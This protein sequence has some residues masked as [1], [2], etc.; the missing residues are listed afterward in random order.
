MGAPQIIHTAAGEELVV[1]PRAD[2]E[3]LLAR[4]GDS[5]AED[6]VTAR[7]LAETDRAVAEGQ[8]AAL[9]EAVWEAIEA[10]AHP[11]AALRKWRGLTQVELAK[12]CRLSQGFV[13]EL[14]QGAK[15]PSLAT[16]RVLSRVLK[17]PTAILMV[18][19][20]L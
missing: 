17:V 6:A 18:D 12:A 1:L 11:V 7:L 14:E 2:Y 13:S 4:A 5:D 15:A 10:G 3:T 8:D 19:R 9:P 20:T 16:L